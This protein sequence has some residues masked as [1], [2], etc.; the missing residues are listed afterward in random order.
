MADRRRMEEYLRF[1]G[2]LLTIKASIS[3]ARSAQIVATKLIIDGR[4]DDA[5]AVLRLV[6]PRYVACL[7]MAKALEPVS[8]FESIRDRMIRAIEAVLE[9]SHLQRQGEERGD[10]ETKER[11]SDWLKAASS[12]EEELTEQIEEMV[13]VVTSEIGAMG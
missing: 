7:G 6:S 12:L 1:A 8:G 13:Q 3:E 2:D 4:R 5:I 11:A 9:G 10:L